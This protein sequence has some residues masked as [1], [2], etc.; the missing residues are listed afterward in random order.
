[1][2]FSRMIQGRC[3][4]L[5][6]FRRFPGRVDGRQNPAAAPADGEHFVAYQMKS[7]LFRRLAVEEIRLDGLS[8]VVP[9]LILSIRLGDHAFAQ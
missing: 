5:K 9:K 3:V 6:K 8:H 2:F 1:M 7:D 4:A